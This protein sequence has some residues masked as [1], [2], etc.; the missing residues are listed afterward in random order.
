MT[1]RPKLS[2]VIPTFNRPEY[3]C[4]TV[5]QVLEQRFTDCEVCVLDQSPP[6][7]A[8]AQAA[9]FA[10][11]FPDPRLRYYWLEAK[12]TPNAKNEGIARAAGEIVLFIDDD[13]ILLSPDFLGAHV[14][15]YAAPWV[16]GVGGRV[17]E[18]RILPNARRTMSRVTWGGRTEEN[19]LGQS[20]CTLES[21][22][23]ANM[24]F[25]AEVFDH[26]GGFD[27]RYTGTALLEEAD[28]ASRVRAAGWKLFFEP[29]AELLHLSVP[30]GGVRAGSAQKAEWFRYRSTA[31]YITK[32]R[33]RLALIPFAATF[34][35]I[36]GSRAVRWRSLSALS[37]LACAAR[38]G[39]RAARL[40]PDDAIPQC[41]CP[42][43]TPP[44]GPNRCPCRSRNTNLTEVV[45]PDQGHIGADRRASQ[46]DSVHQPGY[47]VQR[48]TPALT[49]IIPTRNRPQYALNTVRQVLEQSFRNF[50]LFVVDQSD[51]SVAQ[52]LQAGL[53]LLND[54]RVRYMHLP[55]SGSA[56]ARNEGIA[57]ARGRIALFLDDDVILLGKNFM[58]SHMQALAHP[59][60]GGVTGRV[61]ERLNR[62][63]ARRTIAQVSISG[64]NLDNMLGT[65]PVP[66]RGL[67]GGNMSLKTEIFH[68]IG[69]LDRNFAGTGLLEEADFATRIRAA[70]WKLMFEPQAELLHLSVPA[71]GNRVDSDLQREWW[72]FRATAYYIR[73]HRGILGLPSFLLTFTLIGL[74]R[75]WDQRAPGALVYLASGIRAGLLAYR[76]GPDERLP[77]CS[78]KN[79]AASGQ[80]W[81]GEAEPV[82]EPILPAEAGRRGSVP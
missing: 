82:R 37:D 51:Q 30:I 66:I 80:P 47:S 31:Y 15:C 65:E 6:A 81:D 79:G 73:K 32:N 16:G 28:L 22:K 14:S 38:E 60:V 26:I 74:R 78:A 41:I 2:V 10:T 17:V 25:R 5:R 43:R 57:R 42:D 64:R 3:L 67:K 24:S 70:G 76:N 58:A 62:P 9:R 7:V 29:R 4:S 53:A 71:G 52:D 48:E 13:V 55:I 1:R 72:R 12:G 19:L 23:G 61:V 21:V 8:E 75:A 77:C 40:G 34:G 39:V 35:M 59:R 69:G 46:E 27:R 45:K 20:P 50:E 63:N 36:A 68:R 18:R 11:E 56:N 54:G 49:V 33:G 44:S